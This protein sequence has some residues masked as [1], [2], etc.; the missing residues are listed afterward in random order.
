MDGRPH[1]PE[2]AP[3]TSMGFST[4]KWEGDTL[5]VTTTH[6]KEGWIRR[7]GLARSDL[8]TVIE[9]FTRHANH[10]TWTVIVRDPVYLAE[11]FMRNRDY[12]MS[13]QIATPPYPCESV[14]ETVHEKGYIPHYLPGQNNDAKEY[15]IAHG[16]PFEAA[17][18][19]PES[20]YA[21]YR[22]KIKAMPK[23]PPPAPPAKPAKPAR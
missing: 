11:P 20:M 6:M 14:V 10:L 23:P 3:H 21:E 18:G 13:T 17:M 16:I 7:N 22:E 2:Y 4:G 19:G 8:S 1:P 15:A 5:T 12:T 9:H